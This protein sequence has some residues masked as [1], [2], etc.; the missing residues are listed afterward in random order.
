MTHSFC[1]IFMMLFVR[2]NKGRR[3]GLLCGSSTCMASYFY[4]ML[5][6]LRLK[7]V[8]ISLV[9]SSEVKD[10]KLN[11][12][13]KSAITDLKNP[14]LFC[15]C[16]AVCSVT[17]PN[18][19]LPRYCNKLTPNMGIIP[20]LTLQTTAALK[21]SR[22]KFLGVGLFNLG[23]KGNV[24]QEMEEVFGPKKEA[25]TAP[26]PDVAVGGDDGSDSEKKCCC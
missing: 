20:H 1:A 26:A 18:L 2:T 23:T 8:L 19:K 9:H 12:Q 24:G 16:Y 4:A 22:D 7:D 5:C 17:Y 11:K 6:L 15:A 14:N 25:N 21:K 13:V 10:L 3:I